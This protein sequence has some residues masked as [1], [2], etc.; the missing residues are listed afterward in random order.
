[1]LVSGLEPSR[2]KKKKRENLVILGEK[3][4]QEDLE[5]DLGLLSNGSMTKRYVRKQTQRSH[6]TYFLEA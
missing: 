4:R 6:T 1:M 3:G 5:L 2:E